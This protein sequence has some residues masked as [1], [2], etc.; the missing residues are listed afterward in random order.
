MKKLQEKNKM[1]AA[2][3]DQMLMWMVIFVSF[4][5]M[6]F[7]VINYA[8]AVKLNENMD[9]LS[10]FA[11]RYISN[12]DDQANVTTDTTFIANLNDIKVSKIGTISS[13][14]IN[15]VIATTAPED[16]NSQCIF[17]TQGTYNKGF[18]SNQGTNNLKSKVV[19]YNNQSAA[20]ISCTLSVTIN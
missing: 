6:F 8:T 7:F 20:Q 10:K 18:L 12:T 2:Y 13:S 9:Y 19:I 16:T 3:I 5:W 14:D 4:A 1:K 11:A 15:C 17:E